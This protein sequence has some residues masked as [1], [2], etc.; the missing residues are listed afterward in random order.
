M[1]QINLSRDN[2][3]FGKVAYVV[4]GN[5]LKTRNIIFGTEEHLDL[6]KKSLTTGITDIIYKTLNYPYI[7]RENTK[8]SQIGLL[9][10]SIVEIATLLFNLG[11][12]ETINEKTCQLM[13][14][15]T[16]N[17]KFP[18]DHCELFGVGRKTS[19]SWHNGSP[20]QK[21]E[22][23]GKY[24]YSNYEIINK[25][26]PMVKYFKLLALNIDPMYPERDFLPLEEEGNLR[27]RILK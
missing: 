21:L 7:N 3:Y 24:V 9:H 12:D 17:G 4:G 22:R 18:Y 23:L 11:Y 16:F 1:N 20:S 26:H 2:M 15:Y 27:R 8:D 10:E 14:L 13:M 25:E 6:E 5:I 19:T